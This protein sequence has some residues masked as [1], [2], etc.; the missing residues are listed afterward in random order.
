MGAMGRFWAKVR[1]DDGGCWEWVASRNRMGYGQFR[2]EGRSQLAHR[3]S[4]RFAHGADPGRLC[5]LHICDN[6]GCVNPGHLFLGTRRD[7]SRDMV[8]KG[9]SPAAERAP[10]ARLDSGAVLRIR[11]RY[12]AGEKERAL[13]CEYGVHQA[14]VNDILSGRTWPTVTGGEDIRPCAKIPSEA[15]EV[16]T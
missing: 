5:V 11:E 9:R 1:K 12:S 6:P 7:N 8:R 16:A 13:A 3:V 15:V 14:T 2:W 10:H 4:W